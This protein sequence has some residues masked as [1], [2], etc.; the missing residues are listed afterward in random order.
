MRGRGSGPGVGVSTFSESRPSFSVVPGLTPRTLGLRLGLPSRARCRRSGCRYARSRGR[1]DWPGRRGVGGRW[2]A[3]QRR[4]A[5]GGGE[6]RVRQR[7]APDEGR[8]RFSEARAPLRYPPNPQAPAVRPARRAPRRPPTHPMDRA[9]PRRRPVVSSA[10]SSSSSSDRSS[11]SS[12]G[13][14][15]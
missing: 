6:V 7:R 11:R 10:S 8:R 3:S 14:P 2:P 9:G 1:R 12:R 4:D 15:A 13:G 5:G